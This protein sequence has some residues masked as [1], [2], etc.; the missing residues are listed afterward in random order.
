MWLDHGH[1]KA[2]GDSR[3]VVQQYVDS[4]NAREAAANE[5]TTAESSLG[6]HPRTGSGE[7]RI[8]RVEYLDDRGV[9]SSVRSSRA[10]PP[11][12]GSTTTAREPMAE[13]VFGLGFVH[14]SGVT[15]AGPNSGASGQS[16]PRI[17]R[18]GFVDFRV[19]RLTLQP[20]V[21]Q[22]SAAAVSKGHVYDHVDRAYELRV[23]GTS[24]EPGLT[25]MFGEWTYAGAD[26]TELTEV[27]LA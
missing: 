8:D 27:N 7:V 16:V 2:V 5:T 3:D 20:G 6:G 13:V 17:E 10:N 15:V 18:Q 1:V 19:P 4:V 26:R 22:V 12:S 14:E 24:S 23:R 11:P 25:R 21:Y 9:S